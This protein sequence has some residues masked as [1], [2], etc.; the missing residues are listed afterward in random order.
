MRGLRH[1]KKYIALTITIIVLAGGAFVSQQWFIEA[2][3]KPSATSE[4][5]PRV[6]NEISHV[7][8][9]LTVQEKLYSVSLPIDSTVLNAMH[10]LSAKGELSFSGRDFP[11][12]GFFVEEI[13]GKRSADGYY[14]ILLI[15]G[16]KSDLGVSSARVER[17]DTIEWRYEKGY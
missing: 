15:N 1:M 7:V 4:V 11:G 6:D 8:V 9:S 10:A 14:W 12:L 5:K 13:N 3:S 16:K 2:F 17:G